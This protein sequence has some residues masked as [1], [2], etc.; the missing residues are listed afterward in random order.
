MKDLTRVTVAQMRQMEE[1]AVKNGISV[2]T[3]MENAGKAVAEEALSMAGKGSIVVFAGY[4]NNGGDGLVTAR[5]L[6]KSGYQVKVF[7]VGKPKQMSAHTQANYQALRA[8]ARMPETITT[9]ED[10]ETIFDT[11]VQPDL[12]I[13]AIFGIG[14]KGVLEDFYL[15]LFEKINAQD[16]PIL[17]VDIPSGLDADSGEPLGA[18]IKAAKTLAFGYLKAGFK[19]PKASRYVGEVVIAAIGLPEDA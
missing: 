14:I 19:N 16:V 15:R 7:L 11:L 4:G 9:L 6:L 3:L 2:A 12:I 5:Y 1:A 18:A 10:I 13:D 17:A 8:L